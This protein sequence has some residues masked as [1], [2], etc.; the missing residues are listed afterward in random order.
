[1]PRWGQIS[2]MAATSPVE[3]LHT[4]IGSPRRIVPLMLPGR[5]SSLVQAGY[6]NPNSGALLEG[7][8][9]VSRSKWVS[10]GLVTISSA[11]KRVKV[12]VLTGKRCGD[13][14]QKPSKT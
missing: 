8:M 10:L 5:R 13:Y 7:G 12:V 11:L 3:V 1:M 9:S 6:Q 2:R 4:T 14:S